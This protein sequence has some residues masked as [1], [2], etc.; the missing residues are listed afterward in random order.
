MAS[1]PEKHLYPLKIALRAQKLLQGSV[2]YDV[3]VDTAVGQYVRTIPNA[4]R[5]I[6]NSLI[7]N[8]GMSEDT[9]EISWSCFEGYLNEFQN[10]IYHHTVYSMIGHW[11]WFISNLGKFINFAKKSISPEKQLN[12]DLLKLSFKPFIEQIVVGWVE[13]A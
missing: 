8:T 10:P 6:K 3:F 2:F 1:D 5:E 4:E 13:G 9:Y 7:N 11:D 12:K